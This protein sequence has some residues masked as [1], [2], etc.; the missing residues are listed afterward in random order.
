MLAILG[1]TSGCLSA[2]QDLAPLSDERSSALGT[3]VVLG[4]E[5]F[6]EG[7]EALVLEIV[8]PAGA[9]L[10]SD[11]EVDLRRDAESRPPCFLRKLG[12]A[13]GAIIGSDAFLTATASAAGEDV[14]VRQPWPA[15]EGYQF[16]GSATVPAKDEERRLSFVIALDDAGAWRERGAEFRLV[17][18][19]DAEF[20]WRIVDSGQFHCPTFP[21]DF[22]GDVTQA[23]RTSF[24]RDA[25][26]AFDVPQNGYGW[27]TVRAD[28][29]FEA[30]L[31]D[32]G[33]VGWSA[34]SEGGATN[35]SALVALGPG[36]WT[37]SLPRLVGKD[38][39][40]A[41]AI[42]D[43]PA[44]VLEDSEGLLDLRAQPSSEGSGEGMPLQRR[45]VTIGPR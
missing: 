30:R 8:L 19:S 31:A 6:P 22:E 38:V 1:I 40:A 23:G 32:E 14:A 10:E 29:D 33:G 18:E 45:P 20:A 3:Q 34:T 15:G 21:R 7:A 28:V 13:G 16:G 26:A 39:S 41:V 11:L 2:S 5:A 25:A 4:L 43:V 37:F 17:L 42:V 9:G 36:A 35:A 27:V 24:T 44:W 12:R